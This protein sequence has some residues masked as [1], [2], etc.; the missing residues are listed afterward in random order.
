MGCI[1]EMPCYRNAAHPLGLRQDESFHK[2]TTLAHNLVKFYPL[3]RPLYPIVRKGT[4]RREN[5]FSQN[6]SRRENP[7]TL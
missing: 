6:Q 2:R 3:C 7:T 5:T 4:I 1:K